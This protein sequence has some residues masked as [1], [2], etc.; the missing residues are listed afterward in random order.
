MATG[1]II[2]GAPDNANT[3]VIAREYTYTWP[4]GVTVKAYKSLKI[5]AN[6]FNV[7]TPSGYQVMGIG[8]YHSGTVNCSVAAI[9]PHATGDAD[10]MVIRN[11]TGNEQTAKTSRLTIVYIRSGF[12]V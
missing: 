8:R 2:G 4:S 6:K 9:Y 7:S 5:Q 1:T 10:M 3:M 11:A 12:C